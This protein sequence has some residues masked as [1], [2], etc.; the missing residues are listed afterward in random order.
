[1]IGE[2]GFA[3]M[4]SEHEPIEFGFKT[5]IGFLIP[6]RPVVQILQEKHI[7]AL[8]IFYQKQHSGKLKWE[9]E[10][11]LPKSGISVMYFNLSSKEKLGFGLAAFPHISFRLGKLDATTFHIRLGAGLGYVNKTFSTD[12]N[13]KNQ[14]I[15]SHLN[16]FMQVGTYFHYQINKSWNLSSGI[17]LSHFSNGAFKTPNLGINLPSVHIGFSYQWNHLIKKEKNLF[18]FQLDKKYQKVVSIYG[19]VRQ[20]YPVEGNYYGIGGSSFSIEKSLNSKSNIGLQFDLMY[21][22]SIKA[23][24]LA[25]HESADRHVSYRSGLAASYVFKLNRLQLLF[26][27]GAYTF[28]IQNDDGILYHR[29]GGRIHMNQNLMAIVNLKTHYAKADYFEFGIG[30]KW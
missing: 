2:I 24:K 19:G 12:I 5:H 27:M 18:S 21:D 30:Y 10:H 13:Y 11:S 8:E 28:A 22:P 14:A 1:L 4:N 9:Q 26:Q 29:V 6:H 15:G 25:N 3:Q 23:S 7:Q 17:T 16:G 20:R